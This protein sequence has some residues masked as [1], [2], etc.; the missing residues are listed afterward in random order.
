MCGQRCLSSARCAPRAPA[1]AGAG[2][3]GGSPTCPSSPRYA[4]SWRPTAALPTAPSPSSSSTLAGLKQRRQAGLKQAWDAARQQQALV[5]AFAGWDPYPPP[6]RHSS[7]SAR[8]RSGRR[9][10]RRASEQFFPKNAVHSVRPY[11]RLD[12]G[13]DGA[14]G[15]RENDREPTVELMERDGMWEPVLASDAGD[16]VL[17]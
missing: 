16:L 7:G 15:I 11:A 14:Q 1:P 10:S 4:P 9:D 12:A 5:W 3:S 13:A 6:P 17:L 2:S 8:T